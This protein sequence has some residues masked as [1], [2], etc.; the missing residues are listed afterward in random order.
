MMNTVYAT[1]QVEKRGDKFAVWVCD[2][3]E[4]RCTTFATYREARAAAAAR[5]AEGYVVGIEDKVAAESARAVN[6]RMDAELR[7]HGVSAGFSM[8]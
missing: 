2:R 6:A 5:Y 4:D 3:G 7:D 8:A 1:I